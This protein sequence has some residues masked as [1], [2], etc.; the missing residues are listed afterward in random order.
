MRAITKPMKKTPNSKAPNK[1]LSPS[2]SPSNFGEAKKKEGGLSFLL[3]PLVLCLG[4]QA[5]DL[6]SSLG[7]TPGS[8]IVETNPFTRHPDKSFW[9]FHGIITKLVILA[10]Y[11][12]FS[13]ALYWAIK[14][15][16]RTAAKIV[17]SLPMLY[18]S[19]EV[20]DAVVRNVLL[21]AGLGRF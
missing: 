4:A 11:L 6:V 1:W 18:W 8:G 10:F 16:S 14:R 5:A 15:Q 3:A 9:L 19:F 12:A 17:A 13:A 7:A 21:F 2:Y 20:I